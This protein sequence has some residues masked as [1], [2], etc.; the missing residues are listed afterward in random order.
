MEELIER[1]KST[2][3]EE[4]ILK[5]FTA[6]ICFFIMV[7]YEFL[8]CNAEF[9]K[10]LFNS[11]I[12]KYNFS[13]ARLVIYVIYGILFFKYIDKF[14]KEAV[15][16]LKNKYKLIAIGVIFFIFAC[17][18]VY[19]L[20]TKIIYYKIVL[21]VLDLLMGIIL[22]IYLSNNFEKNTILVFLTLGV[23]FCCTTQFNGSLD[24]K[25]HFMSALNISIGNF[26]YKNNNLTEKS[27]EEIPR[28][29]PLV[30]SMQFFGK[31]YE[32]NVYE[33]ND[34]QL[35]FKATNYSFILYLPSAIGIKIGTILHGS[36][37]DI[38]IMR[39]NI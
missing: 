2:I 10:G 23:L 31:K 5:I 21:M 39:K 35:D 1:K 37:A 28:V 17:S 38:Y 36:V 26:D 18:F 9:T 29:C 32:N 20:V 14:T 30:D 34:V 27:M 13:F 11:N 12:V 4:K 8:F 33:N 24:E 6:I 19:A 3:N 7:V 25:R 15:K 16:S 22:L